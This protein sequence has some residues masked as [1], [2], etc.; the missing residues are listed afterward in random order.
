MTANAVTFS[1]DDP[2]GRLTGVRLYQEVRIP[3]DRLDFRRRGDGWELVIDRPPVG[4]MEYLLELRHGSGRTEL[5]TDPGNPLR[6]PGAF[7]QKSVREFGCYAEPGWLSVQAAQGAC[8]KLDLPAPALG[9]TISALVWSPAGCADSEPLPL[10]VV[11]DGPE[12]D[13]LAGLLTYLAAGVGGGW[14]PRLRAALLAPGPRDRWYSANAAYARTLRHVVRDDLAGQLATTA[15]IGM[16]TSLGGLAM[17]HA[18]CR[19]PG[20]FDALFL[21][22][23]SFFTPSL[24]SQEERFGYFARVTAFVAAVHAGH[25][26][27]RPV[28]VTLTCGTIEE[29]VQNNRLMGQTLR[30]HGYPAEL[31]EVADMHNYTAWRDAFD[32]YLTGLLHRACR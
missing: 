3:G 24:D 6:A 8:R 9:G 29:N 11:H 28:P 32:P 22:S 4:R 5:I 25:L 17:L 19:H 27:G 15:H 18:H 14:L 13:S 21:Q 1:I 26:P 20:T 23:G 31:H 16:G 12:Y 7:G 30:A 10:L 2:G